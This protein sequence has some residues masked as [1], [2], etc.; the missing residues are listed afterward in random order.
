MDDGLASSLVYGEALLRHAL[1]PDDVARLPPNLVVIGP[2]QS[3]KST[4]VN[5]LLGRRVAQASP[6]AGFTRHPQGFLAGDADAEEILG[7]LQRLLPGWERLAEADQTGGGDRYAIDPAAGAPFP[8]QTAA[9]LLL[10]DTPDFDSV[11]S[12]GYRQ[13]VPELCALA[14][15]VLL[16]VS[17]EKYADQSVWSMLRLLTGVGVPLLICLNKSDPAAE[18]VLLDSLRRRLEEESIACEG[19][20]AIPYR[21][22]IDAAVKHPDEAIQALRRHCSEVLAEG[23]RERPGLAGYLR[24]HWPAWTEPLRRELE[25]A[26]E[27]ERQVEAALGDG[28]ALYRRDYLED[29]RCSD[30]LQRAMAQLLELLEIP[31]LAHALVQAR[32]LVTWPANRLREL[33]RA[34]RHQGANDGAADNETRVLDEALTHLLIRL[35]HGAAEQARESDG[36]VAAWWDA[37]DRAL[38]D[39]RTTIEAA[40]QTATV[41]YRAAF[42]QEI[43][44]A[45]QRLMRH[46]EQHP[47]VLNGLRAARVTTDAAAVALAVKSG[48]IGLNDLI[49]A[50]AML[51]FTTLLTEGAVGSYMQQVGRELRRLQRQRVERLLFRDLLEPRLKRLA[52][53]VRCERCYGIEGDLLQQAERALEGLDD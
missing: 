32:R 40:F 39:E 36:A 17:R 45:A 18:P 48:G 50:P 28:L 12:H 47:A 10:W 49:V 16:V 25:A 1:H 38:A 3:G 26:A 7:A 53:E 5:L 29:P 6:L 41:D 22:D 46:L 14:D 13:T 4:L 34:R 21:S 42:E 24:R 9:G 37:L 23:R 2:T 52:R 31:G 44:Q 11:A 20:L 33:Y 30:A 15:L 35:Q 19:V 43:R 51:S 8:G 27:W